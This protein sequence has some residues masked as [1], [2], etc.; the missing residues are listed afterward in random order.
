MFRAGQLVPPDDY[1]LV[2]AVR[3]GAETHAEEFELVRGGRKPISLLTYARPIRGTAGD[4][5]GAVAAFVD[6]TTQKELQRELDVRRREAEEASVRKTRFL[7]AVSHDI[8][9]PANA[10]SLL[11]ELIRRTAANPALVSEIP[12]LARELQQSAAALVNLLS[13]VLDVARFDSG[14]IELQETEFPLARLLEDEVRGMQPLAREKNL[15]LELD[16]P[17][18]SLWVRADRIKLARILGNLMGNAIKFTE[19]GGVK[20]AASQDGEGNVQIRVSDTGIG[21][22]PEHLRHIFDEFFQLRNPERDRNKGTGLGL[23]ICK[24]LVDAMEGR[25]EVHSTPG[26]GSAFTVALPASA[27]VPQPVVK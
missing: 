25:L 20:I 23:T 21:I 9:T 2:R 16:A 17:D 26:K 24:R 27:V 19:S 22:A 12:E 11:A 14:R 13:D 8:R 15:I 1:P 18:D 6:I 3:E 10:I 4:V 7:A 5:I